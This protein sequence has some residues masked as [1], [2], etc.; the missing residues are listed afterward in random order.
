VQKQQL[1]EEIAILIT[2][3]NQ[4]LPTDTNVINYK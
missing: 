2:T 1:K 4:Q 3:K